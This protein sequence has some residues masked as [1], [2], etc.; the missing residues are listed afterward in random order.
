RAGVALVP[1]THDQ[2]RAVE[3]IRW[4]RE[5]GL[6]GGILIPTM[7]G[8][9][10]PYHDVAYDKVWATCAELGMPVHTHSGSAPEEQYG[11]NVGS[12]LAEVVWWA[13]RPMWFL[14]FSGA[15]ERHP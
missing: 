6:R 14:L 2:D 12:Y 4:A 5:N 15:F 1:I 8:D 3:E 10:P 11:E 9:F 13:C 7:W